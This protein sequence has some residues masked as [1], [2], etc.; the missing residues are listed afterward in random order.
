MATE[1]FESSLNSTLTAK[2][3]S[4]TNNC[5]MIVTIEGGR[6]VVFYFDAS[7]DLYAQVVNYDYVTS[8]GS[9]TE[10]L[11]AS[12]VSEF[13]AIALTDNRVAVAYKV[14]AGSSFV[15]S[16]IVLGQTIQT[17]SSPFTFTSN[18]TDHL[19]VQRINSEAALLVYYDS[20]DSQVSAQIIKVGSTLID[21]ASGPI[22]AVD[23]SGN[24]ANS[25][26]HLSTHDNRYFFAVGRATNG[27]ASI[28][29]LSTDRLSFLNVTVSYSS[30]ISPTLIPTAI[31]SSL[32]ITRVGGDYR[33]VVAYTDSNTNPVTR[34][35]EFD[36]DSTAKLFVG[37]NSTTFTD[38]NGNFS[39]RHMSLCFVGGDD[40]V[41]V[42]SDIS[43][44]KIS[45]VYCQVRRSRPTGVSLSPFETVSYSCV[46]L[47]EDQSVSSNATTHLSAVAT[48]TDSISVLV[49]NNTD[50]RWDFHT[51]AYK[52][53][54]YRLISDD[55]YICADLWRGPVAIRRPTSSS[56]ETL[57]Q[58]IEGKYGSQA[59]FSGYKSIKEGFDL[60]AW[61]KNEIDNDRV[62]ESL[63]V[64]D[65]IEDLTVRQNSNPVFNNVVWLEWG[66]EGE[67]RKRSLVSKIKQTLR[68]RESGTG[69]SMKIGVVY[70]GLDVYRHPLFESMSARFYQMDDIASRGEDALLNTNFDGKGTA[71]GRIAKTTIVHKNGAI[72][73]KVWVGI[74]PVINGLEETNFQ[75]ELAN[76][77]VLTNTTTGVDGGTV[78]GTAVITTF[79]TNPGLEYM[80]WH[81]SLSD[82]MT[83]GF[84][85]MSGRYLILLRYNIADA[86]TEVVCRLAMAWLA[87]TN[88]PTDDPIWIG[89]NVYLDSTGAAANW[90]Y[91][92][93]GVVT[94]PPIGQRSGLNIQNAFK[95]LRIMLGS[96]QLAGPTPT[97]EI[98]FDT[99]TLIPIDHYIAIDGGAEI[100]SSGGHVVIATHPDDVQEAIA[101][102]DT[103]TARQRA[104]VTFADWYYPID[105]GVL[106]GAAS[107][108]PLQEPAFS[109]DISILVYDRWM[110]YR[111]DRKR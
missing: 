101:W 17:P 9:G 110:S 12:N 50:S 92:V 63:Q 93:M 19:C 2:F 6:A 56:H 95:N 60:V 30:A 111:R 7:S 89:E 86:T 57:M 61:P 88:P 37:D 54:T 58:V 97:G 64:L 102:D 26:L 45:F 13:S 81:I 42:I 3:L 41:I 48:T 77:S 78:G 83:S 10:T 85:N 28:Y 52:V 55:K 108:D 72:G 5:E 22:T 106:V 46:R 44:Q 35:F 90:E 59:V 23:T 49:S 74:R 67:R 34:V 103:V 84:S 31:S 79:A 8:Y 24:R 82:V 80:N 94:L 25:E 99:I 98:R 21:F 71:V 51:V 40:F 73:R 68:G 109:F 36:P 62:I 87:P 100:D 39:G 69:P 15:L 16:F 47:L 38:G 18:V 14:L 91:A 65:M 20:T 4:L 104:S 29:I 96:E 33:F 43:A 107:D 70:V 1:T 76:G 75:W 32:A 66:A 11:I 27:I 53:T 105:P